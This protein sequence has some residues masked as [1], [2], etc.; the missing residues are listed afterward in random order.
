MP[1]CVSQQIVSSNATVSPMDWWLGQGFQAGHRHQWS[2]SAETGLFFPTELRVVIGHKN[3]LA[4]ALLW[5]ST[6]P[7]GVAFGLYQEMVLFALTAWNFIC[8]YLSLTYCNICSLNI[9]PEI[10]S[11]VLFVICWKCAEKKGRSKAICDIE[12]L[13]GLRK[14][15][16]SKNSF[17]DFWHLCSW[18]RR[19]TNVFRMPDCATSDSTRLSFETSCIMVLFREK[20]ALLKFSIHHH[21]HIYNKT[22]H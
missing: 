11:T 15:L 2:K 12:H 21:I 14:R 17:R 4:A 7:K 8:R 1:R 9:L 10:T 22:S 5:Y 16:T 3:T 13:Q 18:S 6:L 19:V 20:P